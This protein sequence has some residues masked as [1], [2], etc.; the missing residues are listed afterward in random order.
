[1]PKTNLPPIFED[2]RYLL[3]KLSL[4]TPESRQ[5]YLRRR[6][7]RSPRWIDGHLRLAEETTRGIFR[8]NHIPHQR[9][10]STI[11][12][13]C[14]AAN[15]LLGLDSG[16]PSQS[17]VERGRQAEEAELWYACLEFMQKRYEAALVRLERVLDAK[18]VVQLSRAHHYL[19]SE[20]A[21]SAAL[22]LGKEEI[23]AQHLANV[24]EQ[25]RSRDLH[26]LKKILQGTSGEAREKLSFE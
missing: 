22:V 5:E 1:M 9:D 2:I 16:E 3:A 7:R 12:L 15:R 17:S 24:P 11:R 4:R 20:Y 21:A 6:L 25:E 8:A 26:M 10:L 23:A 18:N 13:S 19:A 14:E